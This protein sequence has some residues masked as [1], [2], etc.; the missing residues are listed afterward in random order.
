MHEHLDEALGHIDREEAA[1]AVTRAAHDGL[2]EFPIS[3]QANS[4]LMDEVN[5]ELPGLARASDTFM[6]VIQD[7]QGWTTDQAELL[8]T[9]FDMALIVLHEIVRESRRT[10]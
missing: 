10:R 7:D 4:R 8:C 6:E 3:E 2:F 1:A 9:G 5:Y